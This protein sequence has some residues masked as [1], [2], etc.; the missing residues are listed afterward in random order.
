MS[1][2]Y[3]S[4]YG[5]GANGESFYQYDNPPTQF[6]IKQMVEAQKKKNKIAWNK[7]KALQGDKQ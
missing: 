7:A 6:Q 2:I 1:R 5:D 3:G 4:I